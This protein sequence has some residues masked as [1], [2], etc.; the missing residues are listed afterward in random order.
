MRAGCHEIAVSAIRRLL[1]NP[2]GDNDLW[3][4]PLAGDRKPL[5]ITQTP[6]D[7]NGGRFSPDGRWIAYQS[8]ESGENE[9]YVQ[10]FPGPAGK[11]QVSTG[12]GAASLWRR[13]GR[14]LFYRDQN[15][16]VMAVPIAVSGTTLKGGTPVML[17]TAPTVDFVAS[18]DGQ[19]FLVSTVTAD[20][21]PVTLLL[22]WAGLRRR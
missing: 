11:F 5:A 16:R 14:E 8:D 21:A 22:N 13:D 12:G 4:L 9:I 10:P 7:E 2:K 6:F 15:N 1:Q 18:P 3:F 20:P 17:F 19:R